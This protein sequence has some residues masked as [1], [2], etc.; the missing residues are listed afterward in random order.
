LCL[1]FLILLPRFLLDAIRHGKYV[2][3]FSERLGSITPLASDKPVVWLHSVSVGE[4]QAARPL[5]LSLKQR[6]PDHQLVVSTTTLTGQN[7]ARDIF[8]N[9]AARIFYFPFDW[10]WTVRRSLKAIRPNVVLLMETELWPNFLREC[11][12]HEIPVALVN[13]RLSQQSFRRYRII[14][15]FM[16]RVL[17]S[18]RLAAMQTSE[19]AQRL[20]ALGMRPENICV[21]GSLKFD[22]GVLQSNVA[23]VDDFK[24]RFGVDEKSQ[25]ILAA[26]THAPEE[27]IILDVYKDLFAGSSPSPR[28]L[29]APRHPE[30]FTEV[31]NLL[32][33]SG[34][35]FVRRSAPEAASDATAEVVLL[36]SIGELASLYALATVVFVGGSIARTGGHNILEPAAVGASVITGPHTFNFQDIV[37]TFAQA[38][39][40]RQLPYLP[41]PEIAEALKQS[42]AELLNDPTM[43]QELGERAKKL[44]NENLGA[45][46]RTVTAVEPLFVSTQVATQASG[47]VKPDRVSTA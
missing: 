45:T 39:A 7:L 8:K 27:K 3:G 6:Y 5:V 16:K 34:F 12:A 42:I 43:R 22:A 19:D 28:L 20:R 29:I 30:R 1:G 15:S 41:E 10:R 36:D 31:A 37:E 9:D 17:A 21:L 40:L 44:V 33:N 47:V 35:Q 38:G 2:A 13:G 18:L 26:S 4:T 25:L 46:I 11:S 24:R 23:L 14:K 32:N